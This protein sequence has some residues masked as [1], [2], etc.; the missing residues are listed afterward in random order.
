MN[1][2]AL[3]QA[4]LFNILKNIF[5]IFLLLID[6]QWRFFSNFTYIIDFHIRWMDYTNDEMEGDKHYVG[7]C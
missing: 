4:F 3:L 2:G 5:L 7:F 6:C 1:V